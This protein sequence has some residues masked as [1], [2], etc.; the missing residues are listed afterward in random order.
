MPPK[1]LATTALPRSGK[2]SF[3]K[4]SEILK[5]GT[6]IFPADGKF[7]GAGAPGRM[8]EDLLGIYILD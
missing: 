1:K 3:K 5:T 4:I 6:Y 7:N 8:L 2:A